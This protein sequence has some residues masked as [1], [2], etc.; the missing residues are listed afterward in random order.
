MMMVRDVLPHVN[1]CWHELGAKCVELQ[2]AAEAF[3]EGFGVF[4][5]VIST[6]VRMNSTIQSILKYKNNICGGLKDTV[7]KLW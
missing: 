2:A 6:C 7:E 5:Q 3:E 1:Q 4:E